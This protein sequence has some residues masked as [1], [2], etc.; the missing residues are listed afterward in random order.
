M[1]KRSVITVFAIGIIWW[2][3]SFYI[4]NTILLPKPQDVLV[5]MIVQLQQKLF[6]QSILF[7][8]A[9][10]GYGLLLSSA[11]GFVLGYLCALNNIV[12]DYFKP[13]ASM[14]KSIP[15]IAYMIIVL[16]WLGS[17]LSVILVTFLILF[18]IFFEAV[19]SGV[20]SVDPRLLEVLRMYPETVTNRLKNVYG[21]AIFPYF[22]AALKAGVNLGFKVAIM[23]EVLSQIYIGIGKSM[24]IGRINLDMTAIFS[25]T[26]WI[27]LIGFTMDMMVEKITSM[28][29]NR[30][31]Y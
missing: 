21:P 25:W 7:T 8:L 2:L 5:L 16:I 28:I 22:L 15:N 26:V 31:E 4:A 12:D 19:K 18:P 11:F 3:A 13:I 30:M 9:R 10:L 23:A 1:K 24:Y 6:Y 14:I 20:A 29:R 27:I 17:E